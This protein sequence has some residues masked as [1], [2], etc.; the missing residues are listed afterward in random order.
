MRIHIFLLILFLPLAACSTVGR[1]QTAAAAKVSMVGMSKEDILA[2]MGPA[3]K[4]DSAGETEVWQYKSTDNTRGGPSNSV[5]MTDYWRTSY[6]ERSDNF[7]M[8]NIVMKNDVVT[9]VNYNGPTSAGSLN[10]LA[11]P[12]EQCGYAVANC[13]K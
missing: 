9:R 13:V 11:S 4:K 1:S 6:P 3:K 7:C 2:C 5:K 12:D 8:V 10:G